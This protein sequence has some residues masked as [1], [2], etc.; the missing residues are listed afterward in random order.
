MICLWTKREKHDVIYQKS[1][2]GAKSKESITSEKT[3]ML[4]VPETV[5]R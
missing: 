4:T 5:L 2:R 3:Y 1:G